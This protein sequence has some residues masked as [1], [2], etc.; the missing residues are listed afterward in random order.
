MRNTIIVFRP[1]I[2]IKKS[3]SI[4]S[5]KDTFLIGKLKTFFVIRSI[6]GK[7]NL[8]QHKDS[9]IENNDS[10]EFYY[11]C[12][13]PYLGDLLE[14]YQL[15]YDKWKVNEG[16]IYDYISEYTEILQNCEY[17]DNKSKWTITLC[18]K[19]RKLLYKYNNHYRSSIKIDQL[20]H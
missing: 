16:C 6:L 9:I 15:S 14:F 12:G 11:N 2:S 19:H 13:K 3:V 7:L 5:A 1:Y 20:Y 8:I 4:L 17:K 18:K 10:A